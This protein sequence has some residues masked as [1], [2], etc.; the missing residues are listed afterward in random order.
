MLYINKKGFGIL[1]IVIIAALLLGGILIVSKTSEKPVG[2]WGSGGWETAP[3]TKVVNSV[4]SPMVDTWDFTVGGSTTSTAPL[5]M[6][7]SASRLYVSNLTVA[8]STT[9]SLL[10]N[11]DTM[12]TDGSGV[13]SCGTDAEGT[14][15]GNDT[16]PARP[17][18]RGQGIHQAPGPERRQ[19]AVAAKPH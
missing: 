2:G 10:T 12:D 19:R 11:C 8:T 17:G 9:L 1:G 5:W 4:L 16:G 6:D 7:A 3:L 18:S 13:V 15:A 14:P